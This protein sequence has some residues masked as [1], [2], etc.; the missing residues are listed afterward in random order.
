MAKHQLPNGNGSTIVDLDEVLE[1]T[2]RLNQLVLLECDLLNT[3]QVRDLHAVQAEKNALSQT[4]ETYQKALASDAHVVTSATTEM[5]DRLFNMASE[6]AANI[7]ENLRLTAIA[8]TVNR[9]VMQ[10]FVEVLA[11]QQS[12]SVYSNQGGQGPTPD[13]TVSLNIN[14]RA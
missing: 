6:L 3:M 2:E 1:V 12:V 4:L 5:R 7:E 10:T 8:Q 14:E 9:R 11:E 13:V